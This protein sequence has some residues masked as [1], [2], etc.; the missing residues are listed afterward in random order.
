ME[1]DIKILENYLNGDKIY[2]TE[3]DNALEH[4]IARNK[5]LEEENKL[6]SRNI[7]L[8]NNQI[9][10]YMKGYNDGLNKEE[11]AIARVAREN[12]DYIIAQEIKRYKDTIIELYKKLEEGNKKVEKDYIPKSKVR[13]KIEE[14]E[15]D[16]R[17]FE[18]YWSKD[19]RMFKREMSID[20]YKLEALKELLED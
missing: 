14:L 5:E 7:F 2:D 18:E 8:A 12:R 19:P 13:E 10:N 3:L 9:C 1:E 16:V 17:E 20:Y 15:K 6:N 11:T 4:L